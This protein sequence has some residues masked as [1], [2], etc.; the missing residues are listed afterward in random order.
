MKV[1]AFFSPS[2][3]SCPDLPF[4]H[5]SPD[6]SESTVG[7]RRPRDF[8]VRLGTGIGREFACLATLGFGKDIKAVDEKLG[9]ILE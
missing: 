8:L 1:L 9:S 3:L 5:F 2:F 7:T 4:Q 6:L